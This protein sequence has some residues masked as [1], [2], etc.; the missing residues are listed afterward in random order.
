MNSIL[1]HIFLLLVLLACAGYR[2]DKNV[3]P[4]IEHSITKISVPLFINKSVF[5]NLSG[6]FTHEITKRLS[7][8]SGLQIVSGEDSSADSILLGI[9]T[10][11]EKLSDAAK[12]VSPIFT[13][14]ELKNSI[15]GRA[16]FYIP[17]GSTISVNLQ[18]I[19]IKNPT[20]HLIELAKSEFGG[21]LLPSSQIIFN[22]MIPATTTTSLVS[23]PTT[24]NGVVNSDAGGVVNLTQN[25]G[26]IERSLDDLAKSAAQSFEQMVI[27]VF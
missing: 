13:S 14:G 6:S 20:P 4:F 11:P 10:S 18:L 25:Q 22:V 17:A 19:L 24:I 26:F 5:A 7:S 27:H 15:G 9:I 8:Y 16:P 21:Q 3:N 1:S 23:Y 12:P 2:V